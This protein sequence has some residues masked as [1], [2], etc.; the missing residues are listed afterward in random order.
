MPRVVPVAVDRVVNAVR[1]ARKLGILSDSDL[2]AIG[3]A[4]VITA[5][6]CATVAN[7][8]SLEAAERIQAAFA[9]GDWPTSA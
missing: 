4:I 7:E 1:Q 5:T 3:L 8:V 6:E 2:E 9:L